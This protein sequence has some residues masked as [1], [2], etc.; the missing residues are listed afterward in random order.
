MFKITNKQKSISVIFCLFFCFCKSAKTEP[1][2]TTKMKM[3]VLPILYYTPE[4][5]WGFGALYYN[6]FNVDKKN[7]LNKKSN[8][9]SYFSYTL[10]KQFALE[11]D[12]Q[13]WLKNNSIFLTGGF[14][15]S[16]FPQ[17][18]Y[19]VGNNTVEDD[20][21]MISFDVINFRAKNLT[22]IYKNLY[23]GIYYQF[24]KLYNQDFSMQAPEM[25]ETVEGSNGY[26]TSGFGPIFIID[27]RDNPLNPQKGM[28]LETYFKHNSSI[29]GSEYNFNAFMFDIRKYKTLFKKLVWNG[30]AYL[31]INQGE[32]PFRMLSTLGGGRFLRGYYNGRFRDKNMFV[33][34]HELR[35]P[36]YK[37]LGIAAFGGIGSVSKNIND[38]YKN[39][40]HY[41]YGVGL[42]IKINKKENTNLR[43]D[44]GLTRDSQGIYVLFAEAF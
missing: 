41:N 9:Q 29:F 32:V 21:K 42:R 31:F 27:K 26:K 18:Y 16:R 39:T 1:S 36:I 14:D 33:L 40:I 19:G 7:I 15:Y 22:K 3:G 34:Q 28:Y 12:Y 43:I 4:T 44:Y 2:D 17:F 37:R 23:G 6:Y 13:I 25:C 11:N 5:R 10:N 8:T 20:K 30:N 35:M 38:F 24:E